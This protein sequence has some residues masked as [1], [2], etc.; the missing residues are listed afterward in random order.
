MR[1]AEIKRTT[2][3][4]DIYV[5]LNLDGTGE[6]DIDSGIGFFDHML[7]AFAHHGGFGLKLICDGDLHVDCHHTVEDAGIVLGQVIAKALGDKKG[8]KRMAHAIVPM[9]ESV[10]TVAIDGAANAATLCV[11]MLA[12]TDE[13]LAEK[14]DAKRV[15]DKEIVLEKLVREKI[16]K[17]Q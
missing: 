7:N 3:E 11:E 1:V 9:D 13:T 8:I 10:A 2:A 6:C 16:Q 5:K 12:I 15:A 4:T 14:L 17:L